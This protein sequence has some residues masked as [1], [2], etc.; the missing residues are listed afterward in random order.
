MRAS[1]TSPANTARA[2]HQAVVADGI[3]VTAKK[4]VA[5]DGA[6]AVKAVADGP[7]AADDAAVA[8]ETETSTSKGQISLG[9]GRGLSLGTGS[10]FTTAGSG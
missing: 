10:G 5:A 3:T 4:A 7:A 8:A 1:A 6:V 9:A 2:V